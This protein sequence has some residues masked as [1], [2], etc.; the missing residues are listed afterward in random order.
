MLKKINISNLLLVLIFI[1]SK[2]YSHSESIKISLSLDKSVYYVCEP[3]NLYVSFRNNRNE[4]D[5]ISV[6]DIYNIENNLFSRNENGEVVRSIFHV[7]EFWGSEYKK[8]K[9]G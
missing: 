5:S 9:S 2:S 3:I 1:S 8:L 6:E 7:N 4:I